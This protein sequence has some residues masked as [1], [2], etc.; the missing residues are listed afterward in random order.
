[1]AE[2]NFYFTIINKNYILRGVTL[3]NSI[4]KFLNH[5]SKF[6]IV[7]VDETSC[8]I[9]RKL[10][11]EN[12]KVISLETLQTYNLSK[13]SKKR[14]INELCWTLKPIVMDFIALNFKDSRWIIYM[15]SDSMV[16]KNLDD[17]LLNNY[18]IILTPHNFSDNREKGLEAKVGKYNAGFVAVKTTKNGKKAIKFWMKKCLE[19]CKDV[20]DKNKYADQ[21]Y[22]DLIENKFDNVVN[23]IDGVNIAPWNI[24]YSKKLDFKNMRLLFYHMQG[25][26]IYNER[27]FCVY[28]YNYKISKN[29]YNRIYKP[30][31]NLLRLTFMQLKK[32]K[33]NAFQSK[34]F[35]LDFLL[36][37]RLLYNRS[38]VLRVII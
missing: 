14:K 28:S 17:I 37:L 26:K 4:S 12:C 15:D 33:I 11:L 23:N 29:T 1:M 13:I 2:K 8:E 31:I 19:W 24:S 35:K 25:F 18:D 21:K 30:Y 32:K 38:N 22:L 27:I 9:I 36:L 3:Y 6:V 5:K 34:E 7:C 10:S 20:P 16:F